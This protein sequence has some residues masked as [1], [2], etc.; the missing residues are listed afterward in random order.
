MR[1]TISPA[2]RSGGSLGSILYNQIGNILSRIAMPTGI[3]YLHAMCDLEGMIRIVQLQLPARLQHV[4]DEQLTQFAVARKTI[5]F[6]P[7]APRD[8]GFWPWPLAAAPACVKGMWR[9][10]RDS[11]PRR[12]FDSPED[13]Y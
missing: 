13:P 6:Q 11:N 9:R 5:D 8:Q 3:E 10:E 1:H 7:L 2:T 12:A 4:N